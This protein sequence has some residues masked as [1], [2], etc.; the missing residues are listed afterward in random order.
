MAERSL[1]HPPHIYLDD[2][3]HIVT[4]SIYQ[5]N[6]LLAPEGYKDL[7]RDHLKSFALKFR[8]EIKAWVILDDH[9]HLLLKTK[10]GADFPHFIAQWHGRTAFDLNTR[11]SKRG[12]RVWYSYWDTCIR[13]EDDYW[14]R[15]NYIH[16]NPVKHEYVLSMEMWPYSSYNFYLEHKGADWM[17][18][19]WRQYPVI[20]FTDPRDEQH[21]NAGSRGL[22]PEP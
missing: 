15:F 7:V 1:H 2:T 20:D 21:A 4:G 17:V 5:H 22:Q 12:R 13:D 3:W 14:R 9:Y 11:D 10:Q 18:D 19:V 6:R 8:I 16:H